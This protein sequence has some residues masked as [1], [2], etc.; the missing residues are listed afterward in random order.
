MRQPGA[1]FGRDQSATPRRRW[2]VALGSLPALA[3]V[4]AG[5]GGTSSTN[6]PA[7]APVGFVSGG[8]ATIRLQADYDTL[9]P[10]LSGTIEGDELDNFLYDRLLSVNS[11]GKLIPYLATSWSSTPNSVT[12]HLVS[13]ATCSDGTKVTPTVVA[14][15]LASLAKSGGF[16]ALLTFGG[17][18]PSFVPD[19]ATSTLKIELSRPY[20]EMLTALASPYDSIMCPAGL[21]NPKDLQN[22]A[23][24]SGPYVLTN[25]QRG[26]QYT[27]K[28]RPNYS[29]GPGGE[30]AKVRGIPSTVIFKVITDE[31]TAANLLAAGRLNAGYVT[32]QDINRLQSISSLFQ[33]VS[34]LP[35]A[36][37]LIFNE[38][39]GLPGA[40]AIVRKALAMAIN[41]KDLNEAENYGHATLA[42]TIYNQQ[43]HCYDLANSEYAAKYDPS[44]ARKLLAEDGYKRGPNGFLEKQGKTLTIRILGQDSQNSGPVYLGSALNAIGVAT[45]IQQVN[46][47][48]Y[49]NIAFS[50]A[51]WDI[52]DYIYGGAVTTPAVIAVQTTGAGPPKALNVSFINNPANNAA[53][54][55]AEVATTPTAACADWDAAEAALLKRVD[56]LPTEQQTFDWFGYNLRF[57]VVFGQ[58]ID[59]TSLRLL[60]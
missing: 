16:P 28:L 17:A 9:N 22:A 42:N 49:A 33:L 57:A 32:G 27:L 43:M 59:P 18:S 2:R 30:S 47:S 5:C 48:E 31:T 15:S 56:V 54:A 26:V 38:T 41:T 37:A 25:N 29:W 51:A 1:M 21:K 24:G 11:S 19:N 20:G 10:Y 14:E 44:Q 34:L 23:F 3:I 39:P 6:K 40:D 55:A 60:K 35:G 36:N 45:K 53:V 50:T 58:D 7:S 52:Q 8:T 12:V 46:G 4:L 13:N